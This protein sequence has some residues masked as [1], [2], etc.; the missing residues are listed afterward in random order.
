MA[1][2]HWDATRVLF[3]RGLLPS[4]VVV[5]R[6]QFEATVRSIWVLYAANDDQINKLIN[7]LTLDTEQAAKN[8][9]MVANMMNDLSAKA[10][11]Q[12]YEALLRFKDNNWKALNSYAHAGIHPIR[13][14]EE[15]DP[16]DLL[17]NFFKNTNA[18]AVVTAMQIAILSG[19]QL[20]QREIQT[21][22]SRWS[23]CM[24]PLLKEP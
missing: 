20:L 7:N 23:E 22:V 4:G 5:H 18:L 11:E 14:H 21:L 12:A 13:R 9:P 2:E 19:R 15:G 17:I 3:A 24:P 8:M 16:I 6:A 10:P 1:L